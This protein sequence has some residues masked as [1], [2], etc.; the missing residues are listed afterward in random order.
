MILNETKRRNLH[1]TLLQTDNIVSWNSIR[2]LSQLKIDH[3]DE[4]DFYSSFEGMVRG[5]QDEFLTQK[6]KRG[7]TSG[8]AIVSRVRMSTNLISNNV[9]QLVITTNKAPVNGESN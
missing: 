8:I 1:F 2:R 9:R 3:A 7:E 5:D 4:I 6:L